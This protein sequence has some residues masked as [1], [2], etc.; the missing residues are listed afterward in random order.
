MHANVESGRVVFGV[1]LNQERIQDSF[2]LTKFTVSSLVLDF[3]CRSFPGK[4]FVFEKKIGSFE[5]TRL[6]DICVPDPG[7]AVLC[8]PGGWTVQVATPAPFPEDSTGLR[9]RPR[10]RHHISS[11]AA[12][13]NRQGTASLAPK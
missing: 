6:P 3:F 7:S 13:I 8:V 12:V 11:Q 4:V 10:R 5:R 1:K 2:M 9:L